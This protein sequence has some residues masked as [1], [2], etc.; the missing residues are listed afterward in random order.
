MDIMK[1]LLGVLFTLLFGGALGLGL[2]VAFRKFSIEKDKVVEDLENAL[3][4]LNCG[5]CGYA[6]CS[7]YAEALADGSDTDLT[8]CKPGGQSCL[9][10]MGQILGVTVEASSSKLVAMPHCLGNNEKALKK[11]EYAGLDDCRAAMNMFKGFKQCEYGC[12][13]LGSCLK[14]CPV[15]AIAKTDDGLVKVDRDLCISCGNCVD[16]CPTGV[17]KMVPFDADYYIACNS[18][19]KAKTTKTN[20]SVGCIG[21]KIC[22]K[23]F[24][25]GAFTVKDNLCMIDYSDKDREP[26]RVEAAEK[27]PAKCIIKM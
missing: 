19:D 2:A 15:D 24:P 4:G 5:S 1:I 22:E 17:M 7:G 25:D 16:I 18:R 23:K 6:G 13:G 27:C 8:K 9:E 10:A 3:P 14:V 26:S 21:C 11:Y 20:C 12:L